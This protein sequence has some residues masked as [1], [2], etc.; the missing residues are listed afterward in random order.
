M[1]VLFSKSLNQINYQFMELSLEILFIFAEQDR[2]YWND[3][4]INWSNCLNTADLMKTQSN[5]IF[6]FTNNRL[7]FDYSKRFANRNNVCSAIIFCSSV[8]ILIFFNN[9]NRAA[10]INWKMQ[11][12]QY[13]HWI[14]NASANFIIF[15]NNLLW[16][17]FQNAVPR[18]DF[19][20]FF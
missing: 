8:N 10:F 12:E 1:Y 17:A 13:K 11:K 4:H 5:C 2:F 9:K 6:N 15:L 14:W 19:F 7:N 20:H 16:I 3:V 18:K